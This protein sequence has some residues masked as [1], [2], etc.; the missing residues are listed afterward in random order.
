MF[1]LTLC[2]QGVRPIDICDKWAEQFQSLNED[3]QISNDS[4]IRTTMDHHKKNAQNLFSKV[5]KNG[6]IYKGIYTGWYN[7]KEEQYITE[8][9]ATA[10]NF[11]D[12]AGY[13]C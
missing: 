7:V 6:D 2:S 11:K 10:M 5:K 13:I 4:Y 9:E 12:S 3:L 1:A 8:T